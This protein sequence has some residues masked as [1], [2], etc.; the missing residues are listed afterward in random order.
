MVLEKGDG[1]R[2][3]VERCEAKMHNDIALLMAQKDTIAKMKSYPP[4]A[5]SDGTCFTFDTIEKFTRMK[6]Y[7]F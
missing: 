4:M 3:T 7:M 5:P 2:I 1:S 6:S